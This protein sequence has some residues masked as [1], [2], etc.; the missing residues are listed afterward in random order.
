MAA[1]VTAIRGP[2]PKGVVVCGHD[3]ALVASGGGA[4]WVKSSI[5]CGVT[6]PPRRDGP[7]P[8]WILELC[9]LSMNSQISYT[10]RPEAFCCRQSCLLHE[11]LA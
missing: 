5:V 3:I 9:D 11:P 6:W 7:D 4:L 10:A 2:G 8:V 1:R